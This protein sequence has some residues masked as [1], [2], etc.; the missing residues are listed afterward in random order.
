MIVACLVIVT[1]IAYFGGVYVDN[2]HV[3]NITRGICDVL[4]IVILTLMVANDTFHLGMK[5]KTQTIITPISSVKSSS[6]API[7]I[8]RSL[9]TNGK[10][11]IYLYKRSSD[12][13]VVHTRP[14]ETVN[15]VV[16]NARYPHMI[17]KRKTWVY[18]NGFYKFM[19]AIAHN[20]GHHIQTRNIF[21]L[22]HDWLVLSNK[23]A[24]RLAMQLQ[25]S[26]TKKQ[27]FQEVQRQVKK[28]LNSHPRLIIQQRQR[29]VKQMTALRQRQAL[30][31]LAQE[32][33]K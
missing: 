24:Q 9:G 1:L 28:D 18:K 33:L 15:K 17:I 6:T 10:N 7:L 21:Y 13:K 11:Q 16:R 12:S 29:Y 20:E 3:A 8:Y 19:F 23:Q 32:K 22:P 5:P 25:N 2:R 31:K 27:L 14:D 26:S 4:I 30:E